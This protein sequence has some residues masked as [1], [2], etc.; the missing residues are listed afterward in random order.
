MALSVV[1]SPFFHLPHHQ[2]LCG[3]LSRCFFAPSST[4][5]KKKRDCSWSNSTQ[6]TVYRFHCCQSCRPRAQ[7]TE[8]HFNLS[9]GWCLSVVIG[10][11]QSILFDSVLQTLLLVVVIMIDSSFSNSVII[12]Q[13]KTKK[14]GTVT[15]GNV[16]LIC[17]NFKI[18]YLRFLRIVSFD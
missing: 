10:G 2:L 3:Q 15:L 14:I 16:F 4:N 8:V 13:V 1:P 12:H 6:S 7:K 11:L 17:I 18:L 5:F 9:K